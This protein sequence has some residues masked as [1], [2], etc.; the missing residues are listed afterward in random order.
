MSRTAV[1][2][3]SLSKRQM[4]V[5]F[6]M[7]DYAAKRGAPPTYREIGDALGI[8]STNGVAEHVKALIRKG[9]LENP[10]DGRSRGLRFT[11]AARASRRSQ[12]VAVPYI[13]GGNSVLVDRRLVPIG[14][15]VAIPSDRVTQANDPGLAQVPYGLLIVRR[16]RDFQGGEIAVIDRGG[17]VMVRVPPEFHPSDEGFD[18][19]GEVVLA[20]WGSALPRM[21]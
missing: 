15:L 10:G 17:Y 8:A 9:Y 6:Y 7:L 16:T 3:N 1:S 13:D 11:P 19:I 21:S 12:A 20:L 4:D 5:L 14:D 2:K 18:V